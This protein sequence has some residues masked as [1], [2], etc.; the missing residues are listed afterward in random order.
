MIRRPPRST[1]FPYTTLF[2]SRSLEH[3]RHDDHAQAAQPVATRDDIRKAHPGDGRETPV[4]RPVEYLDHAGREPPGHGV[5][6][7]Q[8][9][10]RNE[11]SRADLG[12]HPTGGR[13]ITA[14]S[15]NPSGS[16]LH[17]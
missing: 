10:P 7:Y 3:V 6:G 1:L 17:L 5:D 4:P 14:G 15:L 9:A 13:A 8:D 11:D 12:W 2:R 16:P